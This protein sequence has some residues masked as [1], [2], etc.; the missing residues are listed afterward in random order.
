MSLIILEGLDKS[1]KSTIAKKLKLQPIFKMHNTSQMRKNDEVLN[2]CSEVYDRLLAQIAQ[3]ELCRFVVNR[4]FVTGLVYSKIYNRKYPL[5]VIPLLKSIKDNVVFI[6][7]YYDLKERRRSDKDKFVSNDKLKLID[8]EYKVVFRK[9]R[10]MGFKILSINTSK[11]NIK[12]TMNKVYRFL[13][14]TWHI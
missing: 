5:Y 10:K 7:L 9:L 6:H 2:S 3:K 13:G 12:E 1:G 14:W 11:N 4:G 8:R